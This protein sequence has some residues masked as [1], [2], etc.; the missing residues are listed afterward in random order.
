MSDETTVSSYERPWMPLAY[1]AVAASVFAPFGGLTRLREQA[2][3][4]IAIAPGQSVLELGCGTGG[5]TRLLLK[6]GA[7]VTAVDGSA[8]MLAR[9]RRRAPDASYVQNRLETLVPAGTFD[10]VLLA[11]VLHELPRKLREHAIDA[12]AASLARN[13]KIAV[14]DHAVPRTG[15]FAKL[16]RSLLLRLEP[17]SVVD[18]IERGYAG[19]LAGAGL[20][21]LAQHAVAGGTAALTIACVR[22]ASG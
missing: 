15:S 5:I 9:A 19:E 22:E 18:C 2:L 16:W 12:A 21:V 4:K 20:T 13:G 7:R 14:L 6:R 17:P 3:D 11:F 1:D 8:T 10:I